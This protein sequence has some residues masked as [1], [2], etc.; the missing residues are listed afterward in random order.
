M[1]ESLRSG[2]NNIRLNKENIINKTNNLRNKRKKVTC[3]SL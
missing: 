3:K 2:G 1:M